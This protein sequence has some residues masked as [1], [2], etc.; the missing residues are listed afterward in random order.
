MSLKDQVTKTS[1]SKLAPSLIKED[2]N[3]SFNAPT[4]QQMIDT[5]QD[6]IGQTCLV[7]GDSGTG[8][9]LLSASLS[10]HMRVLYFDLEQSRRTLFSPSNAEHI[11]LS[12]IIVQPVA[13]LEVYLISCT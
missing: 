4:A 6:K 12:N 8:K 1:S 2:K 11:N 3:Y 9:T 10:K 13:Y 7:F 5:G